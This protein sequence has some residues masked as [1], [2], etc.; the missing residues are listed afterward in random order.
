MITKTLKTLIKHPLK[1]LRYFGTLR[2][3]NDREM[4]NIFRL[5]DIM[6]KEVCKKIDKKEATVE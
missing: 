4:R 3:L 5:M 1:N 2:D 6:S